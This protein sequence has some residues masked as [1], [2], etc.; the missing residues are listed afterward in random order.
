MKG[1]GFMMDREVYHYVETKQFD[2]L[3]LWLFI[4]RTLHVGL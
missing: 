3:A 4:E 2:F 1:H